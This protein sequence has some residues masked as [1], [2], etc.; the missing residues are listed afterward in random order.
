VGVVK[1]TSVLTA[2]SILA[3]T[4]LIVT[5]ISG[6]SALR[7][8]A[9]DNDT[10]NKLWDCETRRTQFGKTGEDILRCFSF[11]YSVPG[12]ITSAYL[13]VSVG[14]LGGLSDTDS[15][16]IAVGASGPAFADCDWAK[17]KMPGCVTLHGGFSQGNVALNINLL[18]IA[19]DK[20]VKFTPEQQRA[21]TAQ[22][23]TG[24]VHFMLQ[25]DTVVKAA[26]LVINEGPAT[27]ECGATNSA[28]NPA[29]GSTPTG[30][31]SGGGCTGAATTL[32]RPAFGSAEPATVSCMT[33]QGG[34]RNV[35]V[36]QEVYIPV[37]MINGA[38]VANINYELTYNT[39]VAAAQRD[40]KRGSFFASSLGQANT[41]QPGIVRVGNAQ[42]GGENGTGSVSWIRFRATGR[43]GERTD[44]KLAVSTINDPAGA[45]LRIDRIDGLIQIVDENGLLPGDCPTAANGRLDLDDAL[46][47]LQMSVQLI[48]I[49]LTMD[50]DK[51]GNVTSRDSTII[52]QRVATQLAQP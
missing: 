32:P 44:L 50:M 51:D 6:A 52:Q 38:N 2:L 39:A 15:L 43:P 16:Q 35:R 26:E 47:A 29:T 22:L 21:V 13:H 19:C 17:G 27:I 33:L 46:C 10:D 12:N 1:R 14:T 28:T 3:S 41:E 4:L 5:A 20:S 36:G 8:S 9:V 49:S 24:V 48:P 23:S 40:V 30:T 7:A 11:R 18:D 34:Q 45:T 25:D 31:T 37:Y 42:T